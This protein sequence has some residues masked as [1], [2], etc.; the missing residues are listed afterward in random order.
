MPGSPP[1]DFIW[2]NAN[3]ATSPPPPV[4]IQRLKPINGSTVSTNGQWQRALKAQNS[5]WQFYQ[6]TMTQ[7]PVPGGTPANP[8]TPNFS[9]PGAGATSAFANTA[10]ET[11]DQTNIRTGCMNCHTAMQNNDFLWSL[12]MNA[13][14]PHR[15]RSHLAGFARVATISLALERAISLGEMSTEPDP[16]RGESSW[17]MAQS[18][19][20]M[21]RDDA[22]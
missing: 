14:A 5:V 18:I 16:N 19:P 10:L 7:W 4:N 21:E 15:S 11:W 17:Q 8:G 6:L 3:N 1:S 13:F 12:Q 2:S 20:T 22:G 9:F